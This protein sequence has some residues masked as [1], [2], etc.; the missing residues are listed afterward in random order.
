MFRS[1]VLVVERLSELNLV[2]IYPVSYLAIPVFLKELF[3]RPIFSQLS[4]LVCLQIHPF[5]F[6]YMRIKS[7][8]ASQFLISWISHPSQ[9]I[10]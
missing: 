5:N 8:S 3:F 7:G 9:G 10:T 1:Y 2:I 6:T 4:S